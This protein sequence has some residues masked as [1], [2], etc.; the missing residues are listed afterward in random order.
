MNPSEPTLRTG[1]YRF[2][3]ASLHAGTRLDHY[4]ADVVGGLSR[5]TAKR[6][7]DLGGAHLCGR[8]VRRCSQVVATGDLVEL[9]VDSQP[10]EPMRLTAG[11]I[12]FQDRDL[13]V[14]DKPPGMATQP[15]PARYQGTLY[16]EL[17]ALLRNEQ[18]KDLRPSI[19]MVQRLDRDTSGVVVFSIHPRAH[20]ALTEQFRAHAIGKF[21]WALVQG[22]PIEAEG[23]FCSQLARRR[24][25]NLTVSVDKGGKAAETR[26]RILQSL[27]EASLV[28]VQLITG[29]SHQIRAHFS[30]AGLPLLGDVAYGGPQSLGSLP[31]PRQM[32]HARTLS[33][34]HPVNGRTLSFQA[35]LPED[36][37]TVLHSLGGLLNGASG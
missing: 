2:T 21:Y 10:H 28:E 18:R 24:S 8:R 37:A 5:S 14:I 30:E 4:L 1:A 19:G 20:K 27:Q 7:I 6:L 35:P 11:H 13:I 25:T 34:N 36:F 9:F 17:Q 26:Y 32:L 31:V 29:R 12:L 16:A 22:R 33:F 15:T 23:V 3:V